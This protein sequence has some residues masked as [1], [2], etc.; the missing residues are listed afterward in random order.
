VGLAAALSTVGARAEESGPAF[1]RGAIAGARQRYAERS[2]VPD[3]YDRAAIERVLALAP[4]AADDERVEVA[5]RLVV[6]PWKASPGLSVAA[7][8]TSILGKAEFGTGASATASALHVLVFSGG[9]SGTAPT[10][11]ARGVLE[12]PPDRRLRDLDLAPYRLAP[13][14]LALGVR[15]EVH[16]AY[17]GGGGRDEY[18]TLCVPEG[19]QL[20]VVLTTLL[21]SWK[22]VG[23]GWNADGSR[24]REESGDERPA[25][26]SVLPGT[27]HGLHD[28]RKTA[29]RR[30]AV[31][32]WSGD[33]Y[34]PSGRDPVRP[35]NAE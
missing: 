30:S 20:R 29:G 11:V 24:D 9:T 32:R 22:D 26:I 28:L 4:P 21:S 35:V 5:E 31:Y 33:A 2:R 3:G 6:K 25:T 16:F 15:T 17:G 13:G 1:A 14:V 27:S 18:L 19:E 7:L 34:A 23:G 8:D 12:G 10:P